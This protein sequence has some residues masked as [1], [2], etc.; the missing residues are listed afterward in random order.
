[1]ACTPS[2]C[3]IRRDSPHG[4]SRAR[5]VVR[6]RG[7]RLE[8][9]KRVDLIIGALTA[10]PE[11]IQVVVAGGGS[12]RNLERLAMGAV[13][14]RVTFLRTVRMMRSS[15]SIAV[16]WQWCPPF[17]GFG[18]VTREGFLAEKDGVTCRDCGG[19]TGFV[20]DGED[21]FACEPSAEAM[22]GGIAARAGDR[23]L[24]ARLGSAGREELGR[25][26][27]DGVIEKLVEG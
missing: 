13:D 8:T 7:R 1:M 10:V 19:P 4:S 21:G 3:I 6:A 15:I 22:G 11:A 2:R 5:T 9:V 12:Q 23:R 16:R 26:T 24:A 27:P 20:V 25:V 17:D 18:Y 14:H